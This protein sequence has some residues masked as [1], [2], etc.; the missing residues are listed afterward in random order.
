[1]GPVEEARNDRV[2]QACQPPHFAADEFMDA[3]LSGLQHCFRSGPRAI[4]PHNL[5]GFGQAMRDAQA[6]RWSAI[7][8]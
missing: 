2:F 1:M 8:G 5:P 4:S 6:L 3:F 7:N